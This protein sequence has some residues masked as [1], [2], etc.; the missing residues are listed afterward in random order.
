MSSFNIIIQ[1]SQ[2]NTN[3]NEVKIIFP[4]KKHLSSKCIK[5][6]S[7]FKRNNPIL[8][9]STRKESNT[10][11]LSAKVVMAKNKE[12]NNIESE[13]KEKKNERLFSKRI[14]Q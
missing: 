9:H 11:S 6:Y 5:K 14:S 1:D 2:Y 8:R 7:D 12:Y 4:L 13:I 10:I 3:S